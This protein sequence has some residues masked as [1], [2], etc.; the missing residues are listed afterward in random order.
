MTEYLACGNIMSDVVVDSVG[1]TEASEIGKTGKLYIG[2]PAMYA[3]S[4]MRLWTKSCKLVSHTGADF[5]DDYK[6]WMDRNGLTS[7]SI[8]PLLEHVTVHE[9]SYDREDGGYNFASRYGQEHLGYL[10]TRPADIE[11]ACDPGVKGMYMAQNCDSVWWEQF[12]KVKEKTGI[13]MM[14]EIE[15]SAATKRNVTLEKIKWC[16]GFADMWSINHNEASHLFKIP[17]ENDEDIINE[18]MKMPVELTLYRVGQRGSFAVTP[19]NAY[20]CPAIDPHGPSVDPTGCGN[21]STGAAMYAHVAG[22]D[23]LMVAI[24]ANI[25][26]GYNAMQFGPVPIYT[27]DIMAEAKALADKYYAELKK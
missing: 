23:P 8:I 18:I 13:K 11:E 5:V 9:L 2:G 7:E 19:T 25:S 14:W 15:Y 21:N 17:R 6:P 26:S 3:L 4:G 27:D 24:M 10:K 12:A 16:A 20:F 22:N 1:K